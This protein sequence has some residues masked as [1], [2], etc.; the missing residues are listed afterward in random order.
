MQ[1]KILQKCVDALNEKEPNISY[2]KGMLETLIEMSTTQTIIQ[3]MQNIG[4][5]YPFTHS[6]TGVS[7]EESI[8][9]FL[10]EGPMMPG[11]ELNG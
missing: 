7:N 11:K 10:K 1:T 8:P 5:T 3:P 4:G 9:G 6:T 2:I